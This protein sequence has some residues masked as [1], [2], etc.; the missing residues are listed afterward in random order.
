MSGQ[1]SGSGGCSHFCALEFCPQQSCQKDWVDPAPEPNLPVN[2]HDRNLVAEPG[3]QFFLTV[4]I[5]DFKPVMIAPLFPLKEQPSVFTQMT[6]LA[7]EQ[8]DMKMLQ[9]VASKQAA[10]EIKQ[11]LPFRLIM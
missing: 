8:D 5:H 1:V 2:G 9:A 11:G 6:P 10:Q 3:C 4:D 7:S